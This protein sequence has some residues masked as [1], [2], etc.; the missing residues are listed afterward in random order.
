[1]I[2]KIFSYF[3]LISFFFLA[4][5][6]LVFAQADQNNPPASTAVSLSNPLG[7]GATAQSVI[8][9]VISQVLGV[10][11]ALALIMFIYG[12]LTWMTAMG[13]EQQIK[14]G[15]DILMWATLGLVIIFSSYALV[16]FVLQ[17]IGA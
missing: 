8:G 12:G 6:S 17:A 2:K 7:A 10:V 14:K 5:S 13:N 3:L 15:K 1:M 4:S 11:G 9:N 16:K